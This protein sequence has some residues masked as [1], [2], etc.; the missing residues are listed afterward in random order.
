MALFRLSSSRLALYATLLLPSWLGAT[1]IYRRYFH[2]LAKIPGPFLASVTKL[3][4]FYYNVVKGGVFY[5][6]IARLH[7]IY[8]MFPSVFDRSC[9]Q[10]KKRLRHGFMTAALRQLLGPIVRIAPNEVHLSDPD[11]YDVIYSVGSK[12]YKDRAFY[13]ALGDKF[14]IFSTASNELHRYRRAPLNPFFSRRSVLDLEGLVQSK[15]AKLCSILQND[16]EEGKATNLHDGFRG[17]SMD[18]ITDYAFDDCWNQ[19]DRDD[20]GAWFSNMAKNTGTTF[21]VM[22]Q[23]PF[24]LKPMKSIPPE[25]AKKLSPAI[26]DMINAQI[27]SLSFMQPVVSS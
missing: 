27:V 13:G 1:I 6:E 12:F 25:T 26:G 23:F 21:W 17:I 5:L 4:G 15:A 11:N 2:P 9:Q 16:L 19:L 14:S 20:L 3:Y 18:V 10:P 7:D 24:L 22:Q 8:G